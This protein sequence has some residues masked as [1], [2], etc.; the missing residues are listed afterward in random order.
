MSMFYF[1]VYVNDQDFQNEN[2]DYSTYDIH[3]EQVLEMRV[4]DGTAYVLTGQDLVELVRS[5][6]DILT[7]KHAH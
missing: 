7:S 6:C 1:T 3:P 4:D 5:K 2:P